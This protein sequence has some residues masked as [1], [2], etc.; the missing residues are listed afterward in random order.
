MCV[1]VRVSVYN[2]TH[3]I[4]LFDSFSAFFVRRFFFLFVHSSIPSFVCSFV[5][6]ECVY[7]VVLLLFLLSSQFTLYKYTTDRSYVGYGH[8]H[9]MCAFF[10]LHIYCCRHQRHHRHRRSRRHRHTAVSSSCRFVAGRESY[11]RIMYQ[12]ASQ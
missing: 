8:T 4:F 9:L 3:Y 7:S 12:P 10:I 1:C 2:R 6:Y 5:R 11:M